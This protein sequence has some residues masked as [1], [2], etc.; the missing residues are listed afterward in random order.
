VWLVA[1]WVPLLAVMAAFSV[2]W[3][4]LAALAQSNVKRMLAYSAVAHA[5]YTLVGVA[6]DSLPGVSAVVYYSVTYAVAA[7]GA[8]GIVALVESDAGHSG[9]TAFA[10][11]HRRAPFLALCLMVFLLSLAGIPPLA[12]FFGKFYLFVSAIE[13]GAG[14]GL[15]WLVALAI[16]MSAVSLYY[17]LLVLK[18]AYVVPGSEPAGPLRPSWGYRVTVGVLAI[19]TVV[20]GCM[21]NLILGRLTTATVGW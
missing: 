6:A 20:L 19:V 3:G 12:G 4:N 8:F 10:G 1:G 17:Y 18:Q 7:L 11:L 15:L 9:Y 16:A 5:G 13:S 2:V 21:P 14:Y